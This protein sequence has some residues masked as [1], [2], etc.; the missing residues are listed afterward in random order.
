MKNGKKKD[1]RGY[2]RGGERGPEICSAAC[3]GSGDNRTGCCVARDPDSVGP[4]KEEF[5]EGVMIPRGGTNATGGVVP[6][7]STIGDSA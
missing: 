3:S 2:C 5:D 1:R 7:G 4:V 6:P